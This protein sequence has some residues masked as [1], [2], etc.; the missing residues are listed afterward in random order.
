MDPARFA[1]HVVSLHAYAPLAQSLRDAGRRLHVVRRRHKYDFTVVPRLARLVRRLDAAVLHGYLFDAEIATRLTGRLTGRPVIG[2]E[3]NTDYTVKRSNLLVYRATRWA[4]DLTIAN[5]N[6]GADFNSR[7]LGQPR[8]RYRVVHNG[9][10]TV[11]FQPGDGTAVRAELAIAPEERVVGMFASFKPQK[12]HAFLLRAARQVLARAPCTRFVFVG[13]ELLEGGSGSVAFKEGV[14]RLVDELGLRERCLFAG[15][16]FDVERY[17]R[18]CDVTVLPSLFE[19]TPNVALESMASG[20]PVV[21]TRVSDNA[22]VVPDDRTGFVVDLGDEAALADRLV[23]LLTDEPLRRRLAEGAR[24]WVLQEF[25]G[26]RLA[27]KT[28][29]VYEEAIRLSRGPA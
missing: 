24:A 21:A 25:T 10:D 9:V 26:R 23:R 14:L 16:H 7:L 8:D 22:D 11:R 12:N 27:E 5:S 29:A 28:A 17:Y 6:A 19:G 1:V 18:A 20:V 4:H 15:N 3:R 13:D 2:S